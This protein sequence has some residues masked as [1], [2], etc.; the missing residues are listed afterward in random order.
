MQQSLEFYKN[1]PMVE[2]P[3]K[4]LNK[5]FGGLSDRLFVVFPKFKR[6]FC[7]ESGIVFMQLQMISACRA[8][9]KYFFL[10]LGSQKRLHVD[11]L[12]RVYM[13]KCA[14]I[15]LHRPK[16]TKQKSVAGENYEIQGMDE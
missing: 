13:E 7:A 2:Y 14:K 15:I 6:F 9:Y 4:F 5:R 12:W 16:G 11:V 3:Y 10:H 1:T 8:Q